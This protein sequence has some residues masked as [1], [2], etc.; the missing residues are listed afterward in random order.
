MVNRGDD[1]KIAEKTE[2]AHAQVEELLQKKGQAEKA[3]FDRLGELHANA[4]EALSFLCERRASSC[5]CARARACAGACPRLHAASVSV[6][7]AH[8]CASGSTDCAP[9]LLTASVLGG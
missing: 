9:T 2:E 1:A 4:E 6:S 5:T 7:L 3:A 8:R